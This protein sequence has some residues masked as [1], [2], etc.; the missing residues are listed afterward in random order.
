MKKLKGVIVGCGAIAREHLAAVGDLPNVEIVALCDLS[1]ARAEAAADRFGVSEWYTSHEQLLANIQPDLVHITT[2]PSAHFPVAQACLSAGLNVLCEKPIT[3]NYSEFRTLKQLALENNCMFMENQNFRYH[4]SIQ[5]IFNLIN[6]GDLGEILDAQICIS[7][8]IF[9]PGSPYVDLNTPHSTSVLRGGVIEDFLPHIAYLA[10]MCTGPV[11]DLRTVWTKH[12]SAS[13][14]SADEFRGIIRG[15][16]ATAYVSFSGN[17]QPDGFWVRVAGTK[18]HAEANLYEPPRLTLRRLRAGE[19]A[20]TRLVD[21]INEAG[22][23][24]RGS[25]VG[26]WRKLGG[27]SSY[28]GLAE[29]IKQTYVAVETRGPPPVALDEIDDAARIVDRF[30]TEELKL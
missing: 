17:S 22:A 20:V 30:T 6:A 2:P 4:S 15:E 18:A 26:F 21:G 9:G 11:I 1:A 27:T 10:Y 24:L 12:R 13:P 25:V 14:L 3:T 19:P 5:R 8:N 29:L 28:D 23:V 7:L 16:R